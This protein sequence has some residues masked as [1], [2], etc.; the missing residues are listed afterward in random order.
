MGKK[1]A[2]ERLFQPWKLMITEP[3]FP[4]QPLLKPRESQLRLLRLIRKPLLPIIFISIYSA[5]LM[6]IVLPLLILKSGLESA[7]LTTIAPVY[8]NSLFILVLIY[9]SPFWKRM[10]KRQRIGLISDLLLCPPYAINAAQK[11]VS[12]VKLNIALRN[13]FVCSI[14]ISREYAPTRDVIDYLT[15]ERAFLN[16]SPEVRALTQL[17]EKL[18]E[19]PSDP[20]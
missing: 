17:D 10:G 11:I 16:D 18:S 4:F 6:L 20:E 9:F 7:L 1:I 3:L 12:S 14:G 5:I 8:A 13:F 2:A 19:W 15:L